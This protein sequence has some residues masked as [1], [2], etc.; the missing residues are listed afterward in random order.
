MKYVKLEAKIF[1]LVSALSFKVYLKLKLQKIII[2]FK[3]Q[4]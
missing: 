3:T 4:L 1:I 2:S